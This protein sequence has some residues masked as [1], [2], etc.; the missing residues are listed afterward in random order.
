MP[1]NEKSMKPQKTKPFFV[2]CHK[3]RVMILLYN[4]GNQAVGKYNDEIIGIHPLR[5]VA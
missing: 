1:R 5:T 2:T 3:N 4:V